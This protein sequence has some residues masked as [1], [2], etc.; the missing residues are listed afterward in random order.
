MPRPTGPPRAGLTAATLYRDRAQRMLPTVI[1][2]TL[3]VGRRVNGDGHLELFEVCR[4]S[5]RRGGRGRQRGGDGGWVCSRGRAGFEDMFA[6]I[7]GRFSRGS[8]APS[9]P[10]GAG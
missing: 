10:G 6:R 3:P 7:A 8:A 2:S 9:G 5:T 1:S 4:N